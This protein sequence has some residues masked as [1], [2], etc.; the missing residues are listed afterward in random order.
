[1]TTAT[2]TSDV[3]VIGA[4]V[5]GLRCARA[6]QDAGLSVTVLEAAA[7][8]GGRV[9]TAQIDGFLC[10]HGF[11]V[12]NPS[13]PAVRRDLDLAA[14]Q[15]RPFAAG[16]RV[17][18]ATGLRTLADPRCAPRYL[19]ATLASGLISPRDLVALAR[20]L[21]PAMISPQRSLTAADT[22][23]SRQLDRLG[24]HGHI[25][26]VLDR[27]L[28]GVVVEQDGSTSANLTRMLVRSFIL[29]TPGLPAQGMQAIPGQLAQ[30]LT[31][32]HTST[33]VRSL[34]RQQSGWTAET[35][36]G[37]RLNARTAIVATDAN[38]ASAL[39]G[40]PAPHMHG[41][42]TWWFSS[43]APPAHDAFLTVDGRGTHAPPGPVWNTAVVSN[44]APTYAPPGQ[45]LIQATTLLQRPDG[46]APEQHV[47]AHLARIWETD[48]S[49]WQVLAHNRIPHALPAQPAPLNPRRAVSLGDGLYVCGD[50]R[51]T[52]SLQGSLAS[53]RRTAEAV[54]ADLT[55]RRTDV[56]TH[57]IP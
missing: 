41:L 28:A 49:R 36:D 23:R 43:D 14:L 9:R 13:Y 39:A 3:I 16:V 34:T 32:V 1:M 53:G 2:Q 37:H 45:H 54:L 8:V 38:A 51:D 18:T 6:L 10:D 26:H 19:P 7:D 17:L 47:R 11:Q 55:Q 12:L 4:G 27:F 15:M 44:A 25:R 20:W 40:L 5:A 21:A 31:G 42:T 29:G 52:A 50:H 57:P 46:D 48:T 24:A 56:R 33:P 22:T 30:G 35:D